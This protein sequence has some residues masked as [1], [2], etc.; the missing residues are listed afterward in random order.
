[1]L[2]KPIAGHEFVLKMTRFIAEAKKLSLDLI[3]L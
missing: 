2:L 1:M 3:Y